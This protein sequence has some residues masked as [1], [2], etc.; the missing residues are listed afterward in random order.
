MFESQ[1]ELITF[2]ENGV[3]L[4]YASNQSLVKRPYFRWAWH[5]NDI[6]NNSRWLQQSSDFNHPGSKR[7]T[8]RPMQVPIA[9]IM[10]TLR[11]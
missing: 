10:R 6:E 1:Y 11:I 5:L 3:P 4:S 9:Q 2:G 7:Q 8:F